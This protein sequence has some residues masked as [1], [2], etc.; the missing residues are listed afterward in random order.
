MLRCGR[1]RPTISS[2]PQSP[3]M[4]RPLPLLSLSLASLWS[5]SAGAQPQPEEDEPVDL[6]AGGELGYAHLDGT[7]YIAPTLA[8]D[9]RLTLLQSAIRIPLRFSSSSGDVREQDWD[10]T[11]DFFRVAQCTRIDFHSQGKFERERG[12]CVPWQV[13]PDD[14]YFSV[15]VGPLTDV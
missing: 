1:I 8:A 2:S 5:S 4:R 14:Y 7:S 12:L 13:H 6:D 15:R 10:E 11:S 3:P 9:L